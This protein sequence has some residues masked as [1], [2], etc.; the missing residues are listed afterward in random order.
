ME[1][2]GI[3][4]EHRKRVRGRV[5]NYGCSQL[6]EHELLEL[7]LFYAIPRKNTNELAHRLIK[8]FG[9]TL[10]GVFNASIEQLQKVDGVGESTAIMIAAMGET[11]RRI[12]ANP[13]PRKR[14]YKN[15]ESLKN[16]VVS[17]LQGKV[18]EQVLLLCFDETKKLKHHVI[19][20]E[21]NKVSSELDM[22]KVVQN[23]V[24]SDSS[25]VVLAHNHPTSSPNPSANDIDSTRM[26]CVTLRKIGYAVADHIIV[27]EN[28]EAYSMRLD[29]RFTSL[30]D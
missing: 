24:D 17:L 10:D 12:N 13:E 18:N 26:L 16:L 8:R 29:P 27:G 7:L 6:K 5:V 22:K 2:K 11:F 4:S 21:G 30:F 25:I 15:T 14:I 20:S 19:L 1:D 9:N 23:L 3:H 28:G